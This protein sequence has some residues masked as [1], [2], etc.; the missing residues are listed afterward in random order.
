MPRPGLRWR[1]EPDG[2][3]KIR[4]RLTDRAVTFPTGCALALRSF[5]DGGVTRVGD[6]PGL[7]D[8][9]SRLVLARRLLREAIA[10][11]G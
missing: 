9:E 1:L 7:D 3:D 2:T 6:L 10:V 4:L 8:D 5:L 11:P